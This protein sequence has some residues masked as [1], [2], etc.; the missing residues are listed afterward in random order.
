MLRQHF[1]HHYYLLRLR[2]CS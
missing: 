2:A 1:I